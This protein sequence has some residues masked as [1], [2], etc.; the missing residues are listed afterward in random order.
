MTVESFTACQATITKLLQFEQKPSALLAKEL[1][2]LLRIAITN[3]VRAGQLA[4]SN[5]LK[6]PNSKIAIDFGSHKYF[7]VIEL[8]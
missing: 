7:P 4:S 2:S 5:I 3:G 6:D 1:R 8:K